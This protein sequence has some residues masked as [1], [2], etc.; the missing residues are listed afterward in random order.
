M[1]RTAHREKSAPRRFRRAVALGVVAGVVGATIVAAPAQAAVEFVDLPSR[2]YMLPNADGPL[3]APIPFPLVPDGVLV[4]DDSPDL[5]SFHAIGDPQLRKIEVVSEDPDCVF[6]DTYVLTG[7]TAV[8]LDVTHG[9]L[10]FTTF[11]SRID[12]DSNGDGTD[13]AVV[14]ELPGGALVRDMDSDD[15]LPAPAV[16]V[17][18]T[19]AQVNDAL[20]LLR[21]TPDPDYYFDGS[22]PET[23]SVDL[24]PG[25]GAGTITQDIDIKVLDINDFPSITVPQTLYT[26]APGDDV[27]LGPADAWLAEDEDNDEPDGNDTLDGE[28]DQFILIAWA[29]CGRFSFLSS[30][31][32]AISDDLEALIDTALGL[33][34]GLDPATRELIVEAFLGVI[35]DDVESLPFATGSPDQPATAFAGVVDDIGWL[36]YH[37]ENMTFEAVDPVT[38]AP[39]PDGICDVRVL[40]TDIGNNGL[41]LQYIGDPP[42]GVE[43]PFFGFDVDT[44]D[45]IGVEK[46]QIQVGDGQDIEVTLP[47][48][49]SVAEG[50][51]DVITA[52]ITPA[53]HP[54]FELTVTTADGVDAVAGVDYTELPGV[55][56]VVPADASTVTIPIDAIQDAEYDPLETYTVTA[57][58]P[59]SPP[60][61][62]TVTVT[63]PTTTVTIDDDDP[64]PDT[65][66]PTVT[67]N[68]AAAQTDPTSVSPILFDVVFSE[69]VTGFDSPGDVTLSG[70]AL[71][72]TAVITPVSTTEYTVSVSGMTASGLVIAAIP[73]GAATDGTNLSVAS[74]SVDDNVTYELPPV[75][76]TQ[77]TV[78]INQGAAQVDP[79]SVSPIVFD[80][81][82]SEPVT[83]FDSPG[84][85]T[86]S[87]TAL[88]TTAVIT[89]VSTTEYTVSVSGMTASGLVIAA[90]PAG[91]ATD[92]T[93]LSVAS[94]ST[95][96]NV[97]YELPAVDTTQPTVTI[98]QGAAQTDP[99]SVSP[100]VFDVVFSEPVTGFDSP[101]DVT[102]SGTA[103]PTTAVIT[104]VSTTEYTVSVSG[105]T[106]SGLVIVAIPAGAATDGTNLSV[107]STSVDDNVTYELPP[108]PD[109]TRPE[110]TIN[111][112]AAQADPVTTLDP[113]VFDVVFSEPVTGFD[114]PSD[115][116]VSG[117]AL[118]T[119]AVI[120]PISTTEY[121]VTVTGMTVEGTVI[122]DIPADVAADSSANLNNAST[123]TD[124]EITIDLPEP[125][126]TQPTV[127][128]DQGATQVDPTSVSP[129]VFDVVFSE[130]VT[131]FDSPADVTLSGTALPTT[132]VI[133][134]VSTT[135]YTVSVSGMTAS[136]TV[137]ATVPAG[138]ATDG[139]NLSVAS[140]STDNTVA[141]EIDTPPDPLTI[142]VPDDIVVDAPV[143]ETEVAVTFPAPTSTG[144]V[145]PVT[146]T[147]DRESGD[148]FPVGVTTVT[149]TATDSAEI[150]LFFVVSDSFTITVNETEDPG[151]GDGGGDDGGSDGGGDSGGGGT[152]AGGLPP[153]GANS[154]GL[155][156][157]GLGLLLAGAVLLSLRR[158]TSN[159]VS[160]QGR[161]IRT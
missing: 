105:M 29:S 107:A 148:L 75:D 8:Q 93:N 88:P 143:G 114:S 33:D 38:L 80:V 150:Q 118:P 119:T 141:Y 116:V 43:V 52:A 34:P 111:Q 124:N 4:F 83:G 59:A 9:D 37:L 136:G 32:F 90:I 79:T 131:G 13:D 2:L 117:T 14:Y 134:P 95:D 25:S 110:V 44:N 62:Y 139:T 120:T 135:E 3:P 161:G 42:T 47:A 106:A 91:A 17:I 92:G 70:T 66:Q 159:S 50:A 1:V 144:G 99:T 12:Y 49:A 103:L 27:A 23:L 149:C 16:A 146:I 87:G 5:I 82:F 121:T 122:A 160:G 157:L 127:T 68:Q 147:C 128:I 41:P 54:G 129:I 55:T 65:T 102:L 126:L 74:T 98:N 154:G 11:P 6:G 101:A 89:P 140:T 138:A 58:G 81:V 84:D 142:T 24:V 72:T 45:V 67:I 71:P 31:G 10:D 123:S 85:V 63:A 100:I 60:P 21:Y 137:T 112:G 22:N 125:D 30:N 96:D 76:T 19:T 78:T 133:T 108:E 156:T 15:D 56:I 36:N 151:D 46:V 28:G 155:V 53:T 97:T 69:P 130:P 77:P 152:D 20:N 35:P 48:A 26:V 40:V 7:C 94:T 39:L 57:T 132:A 61:G 113:V 115:V 51:N 64:E 109:L 73:A 158:L 153:T 18:G 86:L 104:P 145:P